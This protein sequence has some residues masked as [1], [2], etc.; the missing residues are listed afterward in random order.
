[1]YAVVTRRIMSGVVAGRF[2][3]YG[4]NDR[5]GSLVVNFWCWDCDFRQRLYTVLYLG[6]RGDI[7]VFENPGS[8]ILCNPFAQEE[9][10][11][12][13]DHDHRRYDLSSDDVR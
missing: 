11:D 4:R 8:R 7:S 5:D 3:D 6:L 2:L 9:Y 13:R 12:E 1:M 10:C